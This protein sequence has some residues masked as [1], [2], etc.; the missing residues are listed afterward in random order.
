MRPTDLL[1]E[2]HGYGEMLLVNFIP[3]L[4][5]LAAATIVRYFGRTLLRWGWKA[6]RKNPLLTVTLL[7]FG[8]VT[9]R[10]VYDESEIAIREHNR[11]VSRGVV[12]E[13]SAVP[14]ADMSEFCNNAMF[15]RESFLLTRILRNTVV[16]FEALL[17][18]AWNTANWTV[19]LL[20]LGYV[21]LL[22]LSIL[23]PVRQ[24]A[25]RIDMDAFQQQRALL[26]QQLYAQQQQPSLSVPLLTTWGGL[27]P[28]MRQPTASP[29]ITAVD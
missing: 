18:W 21:A 26:T 15:V 10:I 11:A 24:Q 27:P 6:L 14:G 28:P 3:A 29:Q 12:C 5:T 17:V 20:F 16:H 22:L 19:Q 7:I 13:L 4:F 9:L 2:F 23:W 1:K 25:I 8:V